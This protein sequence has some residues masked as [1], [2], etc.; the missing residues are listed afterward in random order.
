MQKGLHTI[1]DIP[2]LRFPLTPR[3]PVRTESDVAAV[4]RL[5]REV[6]IRCLLAAEEWRSSVT[7]VR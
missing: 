7:F 3:H 2:L 4:Y 5:P 1:P 6:A